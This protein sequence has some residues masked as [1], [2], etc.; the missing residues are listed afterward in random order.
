M[1]L[2]FE[3]TPSD[4]SR[5][6]SF[7]KNNNYNIERDID[8]ICKKLAERIPIRVKTGGVCI[9]SSRF[10]E[11]AKDSATNEFYCAYGVCPNICTFYYM[12][13]ISYRQAK[14]LVENI[15]CNKSRGCI[16]QAQKSLN[17]LN[18]LLNQ[19]LIPQI[20]QLK[21]SINKRGA[22]SVIEKHP[23]MEYLIINLDSVEKEIE[24]WRLLTL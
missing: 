1:L 6:G 14:E 7:K 9:K 23:N 22:S 10:R 18:T 5:V 2:Q 12:A 13:D 19:K 20:G 15:E 3:Q 16:K 4:V 17:M 24:K 21:D 8:E 11:C